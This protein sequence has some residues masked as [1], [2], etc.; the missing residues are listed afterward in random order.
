MIS[1]QQQFSM[2]RL[3]FSFF[4]LGILVNGAFIIVFWVANED[5]LSGSSV[6]SSIVIVFSAFDVFSKI[7]SSYL[8]RRLSLLTAMFII[9][10]LSG[11]SLL[12][13]VVIENVSLRLVGLVTLGYSYGMSPIFYFHHAAKY[14]NSE[15]L[16]TAYVSGV[17]LTILIVSTGY[18]G[19]K[20]RDFPI[21]LFTIIPNIM[22]CMKG[23][24]L[25]LRKFRHFQSPVSSRIFKG[26]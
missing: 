2:D 5:I 25:F 26:I 6:T 22:K 12:W 8:V 16:S 3:S 14:E 15:R 4:L 21:L 18:T 23:C 19:K 9:C 11:G 1:K 7:V 10:L 20:Q 13:I 17:N 24:Y